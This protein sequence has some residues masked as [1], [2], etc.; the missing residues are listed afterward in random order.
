MHSFDLVMLLLFDWTSCAIVVAMLHTCMIL[1]RQLCDKMLCLSAHA[2]QQLQ[3]NSSPPCQQ[4]WPV[5]RA[6]HIWISWVRC[7]VV[8]KAKGGCAPAYAW[9]RGRWNCGTSHTHSWPSHIWAQYTARMLLQAMVTNHSS[10]VAHTSSRGSKQARA[11]SNAGA[12]HSRMSL[13]TRRAGA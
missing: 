4:G 1:S 8:F 2:H 6:L 5:S 7:G 3:S 13:H 10:T 11:S 12:N 9:R